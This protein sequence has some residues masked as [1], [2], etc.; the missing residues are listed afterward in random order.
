[1]SNTDQQRGVFTIS[2][3]Y[4]YAWGYADLFPSPDDV[5]RIHGESAITKRLIELFERYRIPATW[6]IVGHLLEPRHEGDADPAWF[7]QD[8]LIERIAA[9]PVGHEIGC[10]SYTHIVYDGTV[11]ARTEVERDMQEAHRVHI[12]RGFPFHSFVFP[13][14]REGYH[15]ILKQHGIICFRGSRRVWY[16]LLPHT[17]RPL[18]RG[19]DYWL[20]TTHVSVPRRHTSGL[21][22]IPES[23]LFVSRKGVQRMLPARQAYRKVVW[24][25]NRAVKQRRVFHLWFHPSNFSYDTDTQFVIFE[26]VLAYAA[27][28]Q[29]EGRLACMTMG[30]V[31]DACIEKGNV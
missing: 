28:L 31:G 1:M 13:R 12:A 15:A 6:A 11:T 18:G 7:D 2:I 21:V 17:L 20:P 30:A 25:L 4:E 22:N 10:H 9:S 26:R 23:L 16:G 24:C 5:E 29:K 3:D 19:I 8:N 14:N 27:E